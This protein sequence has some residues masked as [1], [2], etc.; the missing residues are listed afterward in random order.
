LV[1]ALGISLNA[2]SLTHFMPCVA[3]V[4]LPFAFVELR[5]LEALASLAPSVERFRDLALIA[6]YTVAGFSV[7]AFVILDSRDGIT[8]IR[9]RVL[10]PLGQ[11]VEDPATGSASGALAALLRQCG[12][13]G[14][15]FRITQG[16]EVGRPGRI[17]VSVPQA[18]SQP[19]VQGS[20][21]DVAYGVLML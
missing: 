8:E 11:P 4:G 17:E 13:A 18:T 9:S 12:C 2:L 14:P 6:P 16:V 21:I 5:G 3:S 1:E 15:D 7:C 20:C 10:T 19:I